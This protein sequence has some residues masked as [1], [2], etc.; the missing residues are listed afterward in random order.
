MIQHFSFKSL[1][2]NKQLPGWQ[3]SFFYKHQR[4]EGE[5]QKNGTIIWTSLVPQDEETV[6]KMVHELML[7]HVYD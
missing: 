2:E 3:I 4:Y 1:F 6:K 7:Y 5:Y